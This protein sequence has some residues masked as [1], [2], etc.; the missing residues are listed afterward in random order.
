MITN[1]GNYFHGNFSSKASV[2][3]NINRHACYL[4]VWPTIGYCSWCLYAH[5]DSAHANLLCSYTIFLRLLL[6]LLLY[7]TNFGSI[8]PLAEFWITW[9]L[10]L[11]PLHLKIRSHNNDLSFLAFRSNRSIWILCWQIWISF[12]FELQN[13]S[14]FTVVKLFASN[15]LKVIGWTIHNYFSWRIWGWSEKRWKQ[16]NTVFSDHQFVC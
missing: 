15:Q 14:I 5:H 12:S 8:S 1:H 4:Y 16:R 2:K 9:I 6:L 10:S 7:E 13:N 11:F 3:L